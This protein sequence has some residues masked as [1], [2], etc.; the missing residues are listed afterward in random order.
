MRLIV[1]DF[2]RRT[3]LVDA[4]ITGATG[5]LL[6]FGASPL[7]GLLGLPEAL[8]FWAG[9]SLLPFAALVAFLGTRESASRATLWAVVAYNVLW[10]VDSL[11]LLALGWVEPTVLG[12]AFV[13][14]QALAVA[15]FA[16]AQLLGLRRMPVLA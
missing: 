2:L 8:L 7:S 14:A 6:A 1:S 5:L 3:L 15:V 11:L 4:V 9:V 16:G 12:A 10:V 13:V